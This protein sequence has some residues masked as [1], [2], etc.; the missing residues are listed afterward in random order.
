MA[1]AFAVYQPVRNHP[2]IELDDNIYVT[3]NYHVRSGI[4][5][6]GIKEA[7]RFT[8]TGEQVYYH[9]LTMLSHM[10]D[11]ELFGLNPSSHHLVNV[12]F[13]A[14]NAILLF[15]F[16]HFSTGSTYRSG[17]AAMLF[18]LHPMNV[19]SVAWIAERKNLLSSMFWLLAC[20]AY[21]RY[22]RKR[23]VFSYAATLVTMFLG[24]LSKPMLV[25]LPFVFLLLDFWPLGRIRLKNGSPQAPVF[26][27]LLVEKIPFFSLSAVWVWIASLSAKQAGLL[28]STHAAPMPVRLQNAIHSYWSYLSKL[29]FPQDM[30][31]FYPFPAETGPLGQTAVFVFF[32]LIVTFLAIRLR[33]S[34]PYFFS[35][36]SWFCGTLVPVLG[37]KQQ[38]LWP[39]MADRWTYIPGIGIFIVLVWGGHQLAYSNILRRYLLVFSSVIIVLLAI[40]TRMQLGYWQNDIRLA[41]HCLAATERNHVAHHLLGLALIKNGQKEEGIRHVHESVRLGPGYNTPHITLGGILAETGYLKSA[42]EQLSIALTINPNVA[43]AWNNLGIVYK[44]MGELEKALAAFSKAL[45]LDPYSTDVCNNLA[46]TLKLKNRFSEAVQYY[47]KALQINNNIPEIHNNIANTYL[48]MEQP[49]KAIQ[50]YKKAIQLSPR[51]PIFYLNL[52]EILRS[53]GKKEEAIANYNQALRLIPDDP[54]IIGRLKELHVSEIPSNP[55]N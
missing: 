2:F 42:M 29:I 24:L 53:N 15:L 22:S 16:L 55:E 37:L 36:W 1:A 27:L 17:M 31:V 39:A 23:D 47:Q 3:A 7:F 35:G 38:G 4:T 14:L 26:V 52:G 43:I 32:L 54:E 5:W 11:V 20:L 9:P 49:E 51:Q 34:S 33:L 40:L 21:A 18:T 25:T 28:I 19:E 45:Q 50:H 30:A 48:A 13:H 8:G 46:N 6:E 41:E 12:A 44:K 10:L